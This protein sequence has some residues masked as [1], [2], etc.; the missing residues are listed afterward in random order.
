MNNDD[1]N[2]V[3]GS[4]EGSSQK[5][6]V[7]ETKDESAAVSDSQSDSGEKKFVP[8]ASQEELDKIIKDRLHRAEEKFREKYSVDK[9]VTSKA[10]DTTKQRDDALAERDTAW[11]ELA[12]MKAGIPQ[13]FADRL[14]GDTAEAL[15]TDA[16]SIAKMLGDSTQV[17]HGVR[18]SA[19]PAR[20][21]GG[22][23]VEQDVPQSPGDLA[24]L[25]PRIF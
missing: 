9:E 3:E 25:I 4:S 8:P 22:G 5:E 21:V 16:E 15:L 23:K 13:E 19:S 20:G 11:R 10:E 24:K 2:K 6:A 17:S 1:Q 18:K 14:R 7:V 12:A